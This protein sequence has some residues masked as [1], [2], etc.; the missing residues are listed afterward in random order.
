MSRNKNGGDSDTATRI[1]NTLNDCGAKHMLLFLQYLLKKV[2]ALNIEFQS[3][4]F[5]LHQLYLSVS[6]EYKSVLEM[7]IKKDVLKQSQLNDIDPKD[8]RNHTNILYVYLGRRAIG[9]LIQEPFKDKSIEIRFWTDCLKVLIGV[10]AQKKKRFTFE[11]DS[12]VTKLIIL[13]LKIATNVDRS[14]DTIVPLAIHFPSIIR[15]CELNELD[16][17]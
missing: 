1:H 14:P 10:S 6:T 2:D 12:V 13:D 4:Q 17:E 16:D 15:E 3:E 9:L 7:F 11:N 5:R 8:K